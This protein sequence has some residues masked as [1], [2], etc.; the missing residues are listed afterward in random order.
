MKLLGSQAAWNFR[1]ESLIGVCVGFCAYGY[2][3]VYVV[4]LSICFESFCCKLRVMGG[5]LPNNLA[6]AAWRVLIVFGLS[7]SA[8]DLSLATRDILSFGLELWG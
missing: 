4:W 7:R 2:C 8:R 1:G 6:R 5:V 3:S